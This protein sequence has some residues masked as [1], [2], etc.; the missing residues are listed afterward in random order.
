M[1]FTIATE[2]DSHNTYGPSPIEFEYNQDFVYMTIDD[3]TLTIPKTEF[4]QMAQS[5]VIDKDLTPLK[6]AN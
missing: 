4:L 6:N 3:R 2:R 1:K 5:M